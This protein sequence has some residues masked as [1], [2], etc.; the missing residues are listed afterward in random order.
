MIFLNNVSKTF[1]TPEGGLQAVTAV[2]LHVSPGDVFGIIGFSGAG[3][4][5]LLRMINLLEMPDFGG[6]VVV[7]GQILTALKRRELNLARHSIGMI[8]QHFNL[9]SNRTVYGNVS[10]PLEIAGTP[11]AQRR[12]RKTFWR[13]KAAC[14]HC[15][16]PHHSPE[17]F[18]L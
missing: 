17:S 18:A 11:K 13:T 16:S 3:K 8:F 14:C 9:L 2:S 1:S 10:L 5:T 12:G 4:S 15:K 7:D 6:E